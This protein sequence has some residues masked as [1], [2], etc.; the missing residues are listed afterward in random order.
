MGGEGGYVSAC[1]WMTV[2]LTRFDAP[3]CWPRT[4]LPPRQRQLTGYYWRASRPYVYCKADFFHPVAISE[5]PPTNGPRRATAMWREQPRLRI[6][7][8]TASVRNWCTPHF[9]TAFSP[10]FWSTPYSGASWFVLTTARPWRRVLPSWSPRPTT[11]SVRRLASEII[12]KMTHCFIYV[13]QLYT[14]ILV[15]LFFSCNFLFKKKSDPILILS[16]NTPWIT[17]RIR[18]VEK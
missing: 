4:L 8:P 7:A 18:I 10:Y 12:V 5:T 17:V 9:H 1:V 3:T 2:V 6:V 15:T 16:R 11:F 13:H 14:C